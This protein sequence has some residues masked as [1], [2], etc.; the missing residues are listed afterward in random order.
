MKVQLLLLEGV[1]KEMQE[2]LMNQ[3]NQKEQLS[4]YDKVLAELEGREVEQEFI[5]VDLSKFFKI[6]DFYFR[7][8]DVKGLFMSTKVTTN[9]DKIMVITIDGQEYD[10]LFDETIFEELKE[11][12]NN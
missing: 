12:L 5:S 1:E 8:I 7:R 4:Q 6:T 11:F 10:C 2:D 9:K 3:L